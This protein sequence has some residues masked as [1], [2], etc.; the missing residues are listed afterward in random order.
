LY[1]RTKGESGSMAWWL[2]AQGRVEVALR[3]YD[4]GIANLQ[5][6]IAMFEKEG[7]YA[8]ELGKARFALARGLWDSN[9]DRRGGRA[10]AEKARAGPFTGDVSALTS[11][12]DAWLAVHP[13]P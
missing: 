5:R 12:I 9:K 2:S 13:S 10:L 3:R 8:E 7:S 4:A 6:G 1:A 11:K